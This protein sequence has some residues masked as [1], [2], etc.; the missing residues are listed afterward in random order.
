M[1][2]IFNLSISL[3]YIIYPFI[4]IFL[5][6]IVYLLINKIIDKSFK[7]ENIKLINHKQRIKTIKSLIKNIIKYLIVIVVIT[8]ILSTYKIDVKSIIAGLGV[9]TAIIGLAFQDMAKDIIAGISIITEGQYDV[10]DTI[11]V[12]SF[13]GEVIALG[14]KT[15][16]I[17]NFKGATKIISNRYMDNIVNYSLD[18][19]L[20]IVD[21]GVA[22]EHSSEEVIN[23]L[24]KLFDKINDKV[25]N[26]RGKIEIVGI[27]ELGDSA[28]NYRITVK[29]KSMQQYE[30]ERYLR[31]EIKEAF[32]KANIK[33]PYPQVEVHNGK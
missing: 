22:Y 1:L 10:G 28:V 32:D 16:K 5:G 3:K 29:V 9:T 2:K 26:T 14:L 18:D 25:P 24:N 15:T 33:I 17:R 11:E 21:I 4:Y 23:I 19:S 31:K 6:I 20:A 13:T 30:A 12:D 8:A 27:T 7:E